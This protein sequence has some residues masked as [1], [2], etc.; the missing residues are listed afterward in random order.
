RS[1]AQ[2]VRGGDSTRFVTSLWEAADCADLAGDAEAAQRA[3]SDYLDQAP[4]S[5]PRRSEARWRLARAFQAERQ[6]AAA[7]AHYRVLVDARLR[8]SPSGSGAG[9]PWG[10]KS[11]VPLAQCL[12]DDDDEVNDAEAEDLLRAAVG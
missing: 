11:I 2:L 3:F 5:D 7:A 9:D 4:A 6:F 10:D 12:L 1:H 8:P